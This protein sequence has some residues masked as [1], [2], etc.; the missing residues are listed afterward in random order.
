LP[1]TNPEHFAPDGGAN[2]KAKEKEKEK[3]SSFASVVVPPGGVRRARLDRSLA[4]NGLVLCSKTTIYTLAL[5]VI[6]LLN[7]LVL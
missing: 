1:K 6:I 5:C 3:H 7:G 4:I 2:G